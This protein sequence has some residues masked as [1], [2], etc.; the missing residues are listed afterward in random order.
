MSTAPEAE[1]LPKNDKHLKHLALELFEPELSQEVRRRIDHARGHE[2]LFTGYRGDALFDRLSVG[3]MKGLPSV[4]WVGMDQFIY[5]PDPVEPFQY[6]TSST[7]DHRRIQPGPM[8]TDGGSIPRVLRGFTQFSS[9]G[10][11]PAFMIHD[12]MFH[13]RGHGEDVQKPWTFEES[14]LV[15]AEIMKTLMVAGYVD[16]AGQ[17]QKLGKA[18]DVLYCMFV[19]VSSTV[20]RRSWDATPVPDSAGAGMTPEIA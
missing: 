1:T 18:E 3:E 4:T 15:M 9:W 13:T 17:R 14:A 16:H 7:F 12:W 8:P 5:Q 10:Y 20:A 2:G 6:I 19:A 11:A